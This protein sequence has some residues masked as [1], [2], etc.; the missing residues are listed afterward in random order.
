MTAIDRS[1][2]PRRRRQARPRPCPR[3][4][5]GRLAVDKSHTGLGIG[6][7]LVAHV[8]ATAVEINTK[9]ACRAVI[10]TALN[11]SSQMGGNASAS[12]PSPQSDPTNTD[13]YLLA[14]EIEPT[15]Q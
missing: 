11:A 9:A 10:V 5:L 14:S 2:A 15:L 3:A 6:T 1:A 8:L 12:T 13:L 7:A 4:P